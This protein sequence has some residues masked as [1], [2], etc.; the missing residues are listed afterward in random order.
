MSNDQIFM[1]LKIALQLQ[2]NCQQEDLG[3]QE[4]N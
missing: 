4:S 1:E 2:R 3:L